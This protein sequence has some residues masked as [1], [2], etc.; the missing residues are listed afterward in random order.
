MSFAA[1]KVRNFLSHR[2]ANCDSATGT[3]VTAA[4]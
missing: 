1:N 4:L 3:A 2:L